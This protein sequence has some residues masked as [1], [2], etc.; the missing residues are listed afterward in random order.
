MSPDFAEEF[1]TITE[2]EREFSDWSSFAFSV[3]KFD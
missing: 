3:A 1:H 2:R